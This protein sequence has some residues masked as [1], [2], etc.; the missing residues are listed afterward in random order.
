MLTLMIDSKQEQSDVATADVAGAFLHG[1]MDNF[2][3][4]KLIDEEF[5]IMS[6]VDQ[7]YKE[8]IIEEN[9]NR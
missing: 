5:D 1:K 9:G 7:K 3:T 2:V 8:F 6:K 4:I